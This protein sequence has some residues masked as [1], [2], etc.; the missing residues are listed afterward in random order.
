MRL[1]NMRPVASSS[2]GASLLAVRLSSSAPSARLLSH[3]IIASTP[4]A[5][6]F[7]RLGRSNYWHL[8]RVS[9]VVA[10]HPHRRSYASAGEVPSSV[11]F[12]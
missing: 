9:G 4:S 5:S 3:R 12:F 6:N 7:V 1:N 2:V 10:T 8:V 11:V